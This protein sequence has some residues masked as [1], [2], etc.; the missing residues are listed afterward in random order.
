[1]KSKLRDDLLQ[2]PPEPITR[3]GRAIPRTDVQDNTQVF[4]ITQCV[5]VEA[6]GM[7]SERAEVQFVGVLFG[8]D[9]E[10]DFVGMEEEGLRGL[11]LEGEGLGCV[12]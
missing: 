2:A 7:Q 11:L 1:M 4:Y 3:R 9:D 8:G 12:E 5:Y 10:G 6:A